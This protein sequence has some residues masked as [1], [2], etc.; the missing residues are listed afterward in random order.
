MPPKRKKKAKTELEKIPTRKLIADIRKDLHTM[1][2]Q[3]EEAI[4][5]KQTKRKR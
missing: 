1:V 2:L 3:A 5:L 4:V